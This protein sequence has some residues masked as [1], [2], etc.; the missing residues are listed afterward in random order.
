MT[1]ATHETETPSKPRT[2]AQLWSRREKIKQQ[3]A[4]L[5]AEDALIHEALQ[6]DLNNS[7]L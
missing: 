7:A 2:T 6:R 5:K 3:I 4:D 1:K